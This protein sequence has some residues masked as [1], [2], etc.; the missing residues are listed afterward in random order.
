MVNTLHLIT[1]LA[2]CVNGRC[3]RVCVR[4]CNVTYHAMSCLFGVPFNIFN[5]I[6][7]REIEKERWSMCVCVCV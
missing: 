2:A 5:R 1:K 7:A 6:Y 3:V 4:V